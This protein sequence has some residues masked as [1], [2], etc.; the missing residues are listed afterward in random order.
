MRLVVGS[1][2]TY[3]GWEKVQHPLSFLDTLLGHDLLPLHLVTLVVVVLPWVELVAGVSL[4]A[5][6]LTRS[7]AALLLILTGTF[8]LVVARALLMGMDTRCGCF[9]EL[10]TLSWTHLVLNMVCLA[11]LWWILRSPLSRLSLDSYWECD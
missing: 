5:G 4:L 10:G 1:V 11:F 2:Y 9:G 7:C 8:T 6:L 3:A